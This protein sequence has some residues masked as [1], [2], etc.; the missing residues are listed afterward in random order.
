MH[1]IE[2]RP[3]VNEAEFEQFVMSEVI[4]IYDRI[5]GQ[6]V[7]LLK[8]D[9]GER[10]GKYLLLAELESVETR[11]RIYPEAGGVSEEFQHLLVGTEPIWERLARFVTDFPDP[12]FTDYVV[13]GE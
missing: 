3:G 8:G 7:S 9:R 5:R 10:A 1:K 2:L 12:H 6:K 4:P 13:V 11:D